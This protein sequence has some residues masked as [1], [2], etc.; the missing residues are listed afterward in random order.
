MILVT[1]SSSDRLY[2]TLAESVRLAEQIRQKLVCRT[3]AQVDEPVVV[4]DVPLTSAE[5][6]RLLDKLGSSLEEGEID[7]LVE[8]F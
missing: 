6:W 1:V 8:G 5:A 2:L 7:W 3:I 4:A